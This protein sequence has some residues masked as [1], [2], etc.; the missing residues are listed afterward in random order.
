MAKS[1]KD[2]AKSPMRIKTIRILIVIALV[3]FLIGL[4]LFII[5]PVIPNFVFGSLI[6]LIFVDIVLAVLLSAQYYNIGITFIV[7]IIIAIFFRKMKW[8]GTSVLFTLGF[9][10][11]SVISFFQTRIFLKR[12]NKNTFLKYVGFSSSII[13]SLTSLGLLWKNMHW[14]FAGLILNTG[15]GLYIPFLFAFVFTLPGSNYINWYKSERTVFFRAIIVP[16][17]F[18]YVLVVL[19]IVFPDIYTS[20]TRT[21][22]IPF[23]MG[24]VD[25]FNKPGLY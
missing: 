5:P 14:S 20:L 6:L 23:E 21:P 15:L 17:V 11:L 25:L 3:L 22:L 7:M 18:V 1:E 8:P 24:K 16:M 2:N 9:T 12:F 19:M 4:I 13:L 10:G